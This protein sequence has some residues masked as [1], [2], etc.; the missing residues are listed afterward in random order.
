MSRLSDRGPILCRALLIDLD[1][2]LYPADHPIVAHVD[3]L[4][5]RYVQSKLGLDPERADFLRVSYTQQYG[6]LARGLQERHDLDPLEAYEVCCNHI[7]A[8]GFLQPD[9]AARAAL[10]GLPHRKV[11]FSNAT[12][13]YC[14]R[15]L[16]ALGLTGAFEALFTMES[17]GY[18]GKP[19]P[20]TFRAAAELAGHEPPEIAVVDDSPGNVRAARALGFRTVLVGSG[21]AEHAE[22]TIRA[23]ADLPDAVA[24]G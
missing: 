2:T 10:A 15:V 21:D 5:N 3:E 7:D 19:D 14:E 22:R 23:I 1:G 6:T 24:F 16:E 8:R 4:M 12:R 17:S 11:L 13:P 20:E 18:R 9:P